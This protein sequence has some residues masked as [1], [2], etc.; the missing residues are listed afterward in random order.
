MKI[1]AMIRIYCDTNVFSYI[2]FPTKPEHIQLKEIFDRNKHNLSF[3]YSL[4]H[5]QDKGKAT[6]KEASFVFM[7]QYV[8][9]NLIHHYDNEDTSFYL[10]TP[11]T[12]NDDYKGKI[13][14]LSFF[15]PVT[16]DDDEITAMAKRSFQGI[17]SAINIPVDGSF[18]SELSEE[19]QNMLSKI[20]T[21]NDNQINL[22]DLM[23]KIAAFHNEVMA[24]KLA[25]KQ[26]RTYLI[27]NFN[28]GKLSSENG[29][30][31]F[32]EAFKDTDFKK[33]FVDYVF[34]ITQQYQKK[35]R[36][37]LYDYFLQAYTAL[38]MFGI[39][40]EEITKK[41]KNGF[42]NMIH[43]SFHSYYASY[44]D[45][46]ISDDA[47]LKSKSNILYNL[48]GRYTTILTIEEAIPVLLGIEKNEEKDAIEFFN[49]IDIALDSGERVNTGVMYNNT[50]EIV[51]IISAHFFMNYFN[52]IL[53]IPLDN[54][55]NQLSLLKLNTTALSSASY[56]EIGTVA[57][58]CVKLFGPDIDGRD[59]YDKEVDGNE[60]RTGVWTGRKWTFGPL[61]IHLKRDPNFNEQLILQI[62]KTK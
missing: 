18:Q 36:Y 9:D 49:K 51:H 54:D 7:E 45:V 41:K 53:Y 37:T 8:K 24:D 13:D 59:I 11:V 29:E 16:E 23:N 40:V 52:A 55:S 28:K 39:N 58:K 56:R 25:Y 12:V 20:A 6:K 31:D 43:D 35:E 14:P 5:I 4:A 50:T 27:D 1:T 57:N 60:I 62:I 21:I 48:Y 47:G 34:D 15:Q 42:S 10:A 46:L 2:E 33:S 17:F 3:F 26:L 44:C 61:N 19:T 38:D 22:L 32:N 30:L